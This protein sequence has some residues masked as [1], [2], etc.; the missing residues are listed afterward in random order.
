MSSPR[1]GAAT[2]GR[3]E[4]RSLL[5]A[6]QD[7]DLERFAIAGSCLR[8]DDRSRQRLKVFR[9]RL[10]ESFYSHS[11]VP[12]NFL[13][14]GAPGSG[15]SYLVQQVA[16]SLPPGVRY[17]ELNLAKLDRASLRLGLDDFLATAGPAL[18]FLDEIDAHPD[19]AWPYETLLPYL[20]PP[21]PRRYPT[22]VCLAGSGGQSLEEMTKQ[23]RGRSKGTDLLSR[24]PNGNEFV[25][26]PLEVGDRILVAIVQLLLASH[27]EGHTVHEIEKLA[28]YYLAATPAFA[29]A[30]QLR[31]RAAQ[32]AQR[33]PPA[34]ETIRYDYL[35]RAGDPENKR[36]WSESG[37]I[38]EGLAEAFVRVAPGALLEAGPRPT[39]PERSRATAAAPPTPALT[40]LAVLPLANISPDPNDGYFADGLTDELINQ[41]SRI[42]HLR[43]IAR[44][45]VLR[46]KGSSQPLKEVARELGVQLA[47][48]GSVRK[49]GSQLRVTVQ[50]V[51]PASE[52]PLWSSRYDRPFT[53]IFA[54]QD[55]IARHVSRAISQHL[56]GAPSE[57]PGPEPAATAETSDLEAYSLF[58]HAR[59]LF[60]ERGSTEAIRTAL[61]LFENAVARDPKF[62]RA[63]V[64]LAET[65]LW[66]AT[67]G[68][69]HFREAEARAHR[70]LRVAL[71]LDDGLAEAHS[72]L[73]SLY[74]GSDRL[75][76][77]EREAHRAMELNPSLADPY[78]W[79]AQLAAGDGQIQ[80]TVR[81]LD[82]ARQLNPDDADVLAFY[83]RA[84]FYAGRE[85]DA[86]A[87]WEA[88]KP[89]VRFRVNAYLVEYHLGAGEL[90]PAEEAVREL[91]RIRPSSPWTLLYRGWVD[92]W[93]GDPTAARRAIEQLRHRSAQGEMEVFYIGFLHFA[94]GEVD[95]FLACMDEAQRSGVLPLMELLYSR[96]LQPV[97]SD[98]RLE[99]IL[100]RQRELRT[101]PPPDAAS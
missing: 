84:L 97:R 48:E 45:S 63:R 66:L 25:V 76:E 3:S 98:P 17:V 82:E 52:E 23:I 73:A 80:E 16:Q 14:W 67:E 85:A 39:A 29:S 79:L 1:D 8:F 21:V 77:C 78:R 70:E 26:G 71:E 41:T 32:C 18:C 54:I 64:G 55:D 24:I 22:A 27:E 6:L 75:P 96:L 83:G 28:L 51:D 81:L 59:Q 37:P 72:V 49:A 88:I 44:T 99:R 35:F 93:K 95:E 74:L 69:T 57:R 92:A 5:A 12:R 34:E 2:P 7:V 9:Q 36:F 31:S 20:E 46:Y 15:K 11:T 68:G 19:Q 13:L 60:D 101:R 62:A 10:A 90:A 43:V 40:R 89:R 53:D 100:Q 30:R 33:I 47:L 87:F 38:L 65:L 4:A 91:E 50:L 94:L 58:L 56:P 86:L 61:S 42:A